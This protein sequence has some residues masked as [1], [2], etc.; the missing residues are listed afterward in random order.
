MI[1]LAINLL[2]PAVVQAAA[3]EIKTGES[4]QLD[5]PLNN[6]QFPG[7]NRKGFH[8]KKINFAD[9]SAFKAMDDE[10]YINTQA[11][12]QWDSL[13]H[14]AHQSSGCYYNGLK[15]EDAATTDTNGTHNWSDR[16]GIVGRGVLCDWV[17]WHE[18][19]KG[20][21][22]SAVTRHEIPVEEIIETLKWQDTMLKQGDILIIRTGF[23]RWHKYGSPCKPM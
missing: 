6:V 21:V 12:S 20:E 7:F 4:I 9:F 19:S 15:H 16:G 17:A 11:G 8:Q 1:V 5:W 3:R 10:V 13:K 18:Q 23:V 2:T 14:F 22:P